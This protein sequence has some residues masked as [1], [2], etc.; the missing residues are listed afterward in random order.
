MVCSLPSLGSSAA[1]K[2]HRY[3][4]NQP[5]R[6]R[7]ELAVGGVTMS[8]LCWAAVLSVPTSLLGFQVRAPASWTIIRHDGPNH[9]GL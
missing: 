8:E 6:G 5:Y 4:E 7:E 1:T 2:S 3:Y 9:L